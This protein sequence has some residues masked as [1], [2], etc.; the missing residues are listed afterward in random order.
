[1]TAIDEEFFI[2][3]NVRTGFSLLGLGARHLRR[4][5]IG[6]SICFAIGALLY[7]KG[8][9][10]ALAALV[11]TILGSLIGFTWVWPVYP[12]GYTVAELGWELY[13]HGKRQTVY[14]Y[15]A[16]EVIGR[17]DTSATAVIRS[18]EATSGT[19]RDSSG[20]V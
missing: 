13:H 5:T 7:L 9:H 11:T 8:L 2:P 16:K 4:A 17:A 20:M 14:H 10:I 18:L 1:M 15:Q 12:G 6:A 3:E 19:S